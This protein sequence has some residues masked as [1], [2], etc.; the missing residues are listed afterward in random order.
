MGR[1]AA[2]IGCCVAFFFVSSAEASPSS[3]APIASVSTS[4]SSA[5]AKAIEAAK[6][7]R[8]TLDIR[9]VELG[10]EREKLEAERRVSGA[11]RE[12]AEERAAAR[13]PGWVWPVGA[14]ALIAAFAAGV[15]VGASR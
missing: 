6:L 3:R 15:G 11:L 10:A 1:R 9:E 8:G 14:V 5:A 12:L 4:S 13:L 2:V 7:F